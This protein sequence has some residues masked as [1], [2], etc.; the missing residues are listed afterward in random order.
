[1]KKETGICPPTTCIGGQIHRF[2]RILEG[3]DFTEGIDM[4]ATKDQARKKGGGGSPKT[5][6]AYGYEILPSQGADPMKEIGTLL[7]KEH[8]NAKRGERVWA[9]RL[10][11]EQRITHIMVVSDSP[12]Q[13]GEINK[14]IENRLEEL[15]AGY[16]L[17]APLA[18]VDGDE[19][20]PPTSPPPTEEEP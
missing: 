11:R 20:Q 15:N 13:T 18:V 10:V 16:F 2:G 14:L 8:E 9:G 6:W 1:M 3:R 17:S 12:D 19:A 7:S 5:L 4:M